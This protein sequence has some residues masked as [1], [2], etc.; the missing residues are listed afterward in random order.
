LPKLILATRNAAKAR[1]YALLLG[2]IPFEIVTLDE[3]GIETEVSETGDTMEQNAALKAVACASQSNLLA[4]A[5]DSGLEVDALGGEP[6]VLSAR[7]AGPGASDEERIEHLLKRIEDVPWEKRS[8]RFRCVIAIAT[9][10]GEV[11]LCCG[12]CQGI[13]VP[14]PMGKNGFGYDPIFYLPERGKTMAE[15]SMEEKNEISHRGLA[16]E[17]A[18]QALV[19]RQSGRKE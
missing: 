12:E 17:Q 8:A 3:Q 1:E 19:K 7:Y 10:E 18:R 16:A 5:D 13:I 14:S 15:L 9:P 2:E 6:G 11:E 4:L